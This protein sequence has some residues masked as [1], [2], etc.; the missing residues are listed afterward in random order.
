MCITK[1]YLTKTC[2]WVQCKRILE[3]GKVETTL[4][5]IIVWKN[6][7]WW[8]RGYDKEEYKV[9]EK[10]IFGKRERKHREF[11]IVETT[12][13]YIVACLWQSLKRWTRVQHREKSREYEKDNNNWKKWEKACVGIEHRCRTCV[14]LSFFWKIF[15]FSCFEYFLSFGKSFNFLFWIF[16]LT[17][18]VIC[19]PNSFVL[20]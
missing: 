4:Q 2:Q 16:S 8:N 1:I 18:L 19:V 17:F 6:L 9:C 11:G 7:K 15:S 3:F 14:Q 13:R 12:L 5:W 10:Q 20:D